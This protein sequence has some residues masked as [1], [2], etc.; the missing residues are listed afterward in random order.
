MRSIELTL[1]D[2]ADAAVRADWT[3]LAAAGLRSLAHHVGPSNRPHITLAAGEELA[4]SVALRS[5]LQAIPIPVRFGGFV[6]FGV[7]RRG[8][9][10]ARHVVASAELLALHRAVHDAAP[11]AVELTLPG[12]W[13][14]HVTLARR[15]SADELA[16]ALPLLGPLPPAAAMAARLWDGVTK[17][18]TPLT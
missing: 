5:A 1:G 4:D 13:T 18:L 2:E 7:G 12:R 16:H 6:V 10:L 14:P 15:V 3:T 11:G 17:E 8:F 9:V